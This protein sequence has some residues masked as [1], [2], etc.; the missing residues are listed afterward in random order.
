[1]NVSELLEANGITLRHASPGRYDVLCPRCSAERA[2][3]EHRRTKC[4]NVVVEGDD[5][6][7]WRCNHC[8]WSGPEKGS[9]AKRNG[10]DRPAL[11]TYEY[12]DVDGELR[13]RKIRNLPGRSSRFWL[14]RPDGKGGWINRATGVDTNVLYRVDEVA[15]AIGAGHVVCCVEG[16][17][18]VDNLCRLG[19]VA[20]C[21]SLGA[22]E[23]AK[24]P[25]WKPEH[26]AQLAGADLVVLNDDDAASYA[27]AD[28]TCRLSL[29]IAKRVRRLA[30]NFQEVVH[31]V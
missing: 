5:R 4:L 6:T 26:S 30:V 15:K 14:E 25:K 21:N 27:H 12:R 13:F 24:A 2:T 16:E 31:S 18:D 29:G 1:M 9:G 3:A 17:K 22:S 7:F 10:A 28:A 23:M 8:N 20:T 19:F 11:T